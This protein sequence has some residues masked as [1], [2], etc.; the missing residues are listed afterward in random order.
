ELKPEEGKD[1]ITNSQKYLA[2]AQSSFSDDE[3]LKAFSAIME[4]GTYNK[5]KSSLE[6]GGSM[7]A[8]AQIMSDISHLKPE[9]G[10]NSVSDYQKYMAA[11]GSDFSEEERMAVL[12]TL[13]SDSQYSGLQRAVM[14]G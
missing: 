1:S 9:S 12:G 7:Q 4:E 5:F 14:A 3:K 6:L 2:I 10:K 13:M 8:Y 11:A